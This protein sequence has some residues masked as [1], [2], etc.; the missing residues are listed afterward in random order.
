[1][2]MEKQEKL[3]TLLAQLQ[4]FV[5]EFKYSEEKPIYY[6]NWVKRLIYLKM[7]TRKFLQK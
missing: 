2:T 5:D 6:W 7:Q 3:K 1:M 4:P